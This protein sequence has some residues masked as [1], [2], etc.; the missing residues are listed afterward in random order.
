ML[1]VVSH[2]NYV[3]PGRS[4][5]GKPVEK[6]REWAHQSSPARWWETPSY[7]RHECCIPRGGCMATG[8]SHRPIP[9]TDPEG[10]CPSDYRIDLLLAGELDPHA[11]EKMRDHIAACSGCQA[12]VLEFESQIRS[13]GVASSPRRHTTQSLILAGPSWSVLAIAAGAALVLFLIFRQLAPAQTA[14]AE[15]EYSLALLNGQRLVYSSREP[16]YLTVLGVERGGAVTVFYPSDEQPHLAQAGREVKLAV[17]QKL[18][19]RIE[20]ATLLGFFCQRPI[21]PA[22]LS[23][24]VRDRQGAL[25]PPEGCEEVSWRGIKTSSR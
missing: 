22:E 17:A 23:A 16:R 13:F 4:F 19:E 1:E 5:G 3:L 15:A 6:L 14:A 10:V 25:Q 8:P 12:R 24:R 20:S 21:T 9:S 11:E 18:T 7:L 2:Q